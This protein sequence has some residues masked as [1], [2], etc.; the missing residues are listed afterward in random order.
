MGTNLAVPT[1]VN[2]KVCRAGKIW[3]LG[4]HPHKGRG[5]ANRQGEH[6][7]NRETKTPKPRSSIRDRARR[8]EPL[9]PAG[10]YGGAMKKGGGYKIGPRACLSL[11]AV[12]CCRPKSR[13][14]P[15]PLTVQR[16]GAASAARC[17]TWRGTLRA[18]VLGN[19]DKNENGAAGK[20]EGVRLGTGGGFDRRLRGR[21]VERVPV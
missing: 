18:D 3:G 1:I 5:Q 6:D 17:G 20:E 19:F 2:G 14:V 10:W 8:G 15:G 4:L 13:S 9:H 16:N 12:C 11:T 21:L 7:G